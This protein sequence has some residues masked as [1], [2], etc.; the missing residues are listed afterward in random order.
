VSSWFERFIK[1]PYTIISLLGIFLFLGVYGYNSLNRKLFPDSNRPEVALVIQWGGATAKDLASKVAVVVERELYTIDKVRRVYSTTIDEVSVIRAEFEYTKDIDTAVSD[2]SNALSRIKALL[3]PSIKEPRIY[4]ITSATPPVMVIGVS[5]KDLMLIREILEN[6]IKNKLLKVEGVANVDIFGGYKKEIIVKVDKEKLNSLGLNTAKVVAILS[7]NDRDYALGSLDLERG[8]FL[9][10]IE[11]KRDQIEKIRNLPLTPDIKLKDVATI[12]YSNYD[13]TALYFGNSKESI[14]LA[15][16]RATD[17]DVI[18][19]INAVEKKL[20]EIKRQYPALDFE[21]TDT[22]KDTIEQSIANMF[23]SLRDAIVMST[24][25]AFFFLASL[26]QVLVVLFTIP[27]VYAST[28]AMM[29]M[30]GIEFNVVTLTAIILALGL[31]LDDA[32]V[33]MENIERHYKEL[34]KPIEQA[35]I[36]G[37]KEIMFAD[38]SGT[39]TT[40]VAL[41]PIMFVGDY[42]QTIFRPL[43]GTL[44]LALGA[45]Y[46]ISIT[47]VPLLSLKFLAIQNRYVLA[48]E[49]GFSKISNAFNN[50]AKEFFKGLAKSAMESKLIATSYF[51]ILFILFVISAKGVMP[52][53][54]QELMPPMD[55]G[56][57]KIQV[58]MDSNLPIQE[59]AKTLKEIDKILQKVAPLVRVSAS[60]GSEPGVLS[61]GSGSGIDN[62]SITATYVNRFERKKTIWEIER[63]IRKEIAK[64]PNIKY[65]SVFDY[66]ATALSSIRGNVDVMLSGDD[67]KELKEAGDKLY[68]VLLHTKGLVNISKSWEL[69]K[70][71]FILKIDEE[72]ALSYEITSKDIATQ[73]ALYLRGAFS[74]SKSVKNSNDILVRVWGDNRRMIKEFTLTTPKGLVPL[75]EIATLTKKVQP[76]VITREGLEYTIDIYGFREKAAIS[77]IMANFEKAFKGTKLPPTIKMAQ[78]GDIAQ[79]TDSAKRMV[80][81]VIFGVLLIFF[82]LVPMFNSFKAPLLIIFSIPLTLIGAAWILL[83]LD[84]HTSMPAMMG[85][86]LLSGIIVNNAI[87]LIEFALMGIEQG[88][89]AKEAMLRS[90]DVR[91]RPV[92]MTAFATTAGMLPVALGWAIGLE[93]LAPLGAVAIGGL[94]VG[95]FLTLVFIP[96]VF[97]WLY[98]NTPVKSPEAVGG[99]KGS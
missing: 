69:D 25:V 38:L 66:G 36:E 11:G 4:K 54:G 37:T 89:S 52:L 19:T 64:L 6:D 50:G 12:T 3:P 86:I 97:T 88:L 93:R 75:E 21:I 98:S 9:L 29:Y 59:S 90:I 57:V 53:V 26:R 79:F 30:V 56:I 47:T 7:K 18:K 58:Q 80:K 71:V 68:K 83:L 41:V 2:V 24:I 5:G 73:L 81:A 42:P 78:A 43:V 60:I 77:H 70:E 10:K 55:T 63:E 31:L 44:L 15:I 85:F 61:M 65:F 51:L 67:F 1:K 27:L 96:I 46:I 23:E 20:E 99:W 13:N 35:V 72:K 17:A 91:T 95:T 62:I 76:N 22:Q 32:V 14:A 16:Q 84:Y 28:V 33:V 8:K 49:R 74:A 87:L 92:L 82:V 45:S 39:I 48:F 40:M 34:N 94:M